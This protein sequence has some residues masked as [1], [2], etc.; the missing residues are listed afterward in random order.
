MSLPGQSAPKDGCEHA[1]G[2]PIKLGPIAP[3]GFEV[4]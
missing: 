4:E 2:P 1:S 3:I